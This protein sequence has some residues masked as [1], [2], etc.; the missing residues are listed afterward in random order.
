M[1]SLYERLGGRHA[2]HT[3]IDLFYYKV[4]QDPALKH[5][6]DGADM[7][8]LKEHQLEFMTYIFGGSQKDYPLERL[9]ESHANLHITD[10]EFD[11]TCN[12]LR[13]AMQGLALPAPLQNEVMNVVAK[14]RDAIVTA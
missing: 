14:T 2:L 6:F 1:E 4:L 5:R 9:H 10:A 12:H 3:L 13:N 11:A 7:M 8:S